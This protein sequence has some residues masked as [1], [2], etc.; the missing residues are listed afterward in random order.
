MSET[1]SPFYELGRLLRRIILPATEKCEAVTTPIKPLPVKPVSVPAALPIKGSSARGMGAAIAP[2]IKPLPS[3]VELPRPSVSPPDCSDRERLIAALRSGA[4]AIL[5]HGRAGTGKTTLIQ[6]LKGEGLRHVVV[7]PTGIAALNAGGQTIHKFFGIPPRIVNLDD[8]N[9]RNRLG[10]ILRRI[11]LI[12]IDEVSMVRADLLDVVDRTLRVHLD[13]DKLFGGITIL[14]VGDFLQLPPIVEEHDAPIL[15]HRGYEITHAFGAKCIQNLRELKLIELSTVYRQ[16][17]PE[18]LELLHNVRTGESLE[19][20]VRRLN[21]RCHREH[22]TSSKPI[23]LTSRTEAA[24]EYN[25]RGLA[26]LPGNAIRF[27]GAIE[28][29]FRILRDRLPAPEHLDLKKG[30]RIMMVKND[31]EKRWVNGSLGTVSNLSPATVWVRL[32][33]SANEEE[34]H[35]ATWESIE[36]RY[37]TFTRRVNPVVVGTYTQ[38][39]IAPAWAMTIHKAQGLTLDDVRIDLGH[40]AFS[41]GQAYVALSRART[42]QG[43]SLAQPLRISDVM[44]DAKLVEG[45]RRIAAHG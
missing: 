14:L 42:L 2:P 4:P 15:Q 11:D 25:R 38:F 3:L 44:A 19:D 35:K 24:S 41:A 45:V 9:P 34:V 30:A 18:F 1:R 20:T 5:L 29:D 7:A 32:D 17:D 43:L 27:V 40:G 10:S 36:Y 16:S 33:G 37:D 8:I 12:V 39:P 13:P 26:D 31:P 21:L 6:S 23:I 22:R 28:N